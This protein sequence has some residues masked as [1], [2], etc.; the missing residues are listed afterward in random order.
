MTSLEIQRYLDGDHPRQSDADDHL[1]QCARC[2]IELHR[3]QALYQGLREDSGFELSPG[4]AESVAA[5]LAVASPRVT[6]LGRAGFVF[7]VLGFAM[8]ALASAY[9]LYQA[10]IIERLAAIASGTIESG[11]FLLALLQQAALRS[12]IGVPVIVSIVV[13][14]AG[15]TV[16]DQVLLRRRSGLLFV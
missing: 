15:L 9:F 12:G 11:Q 4:F 7:A 1:R 2:Q 14:L 6:V 5:R 3:Y 10:S 8:A 13:V 16:A